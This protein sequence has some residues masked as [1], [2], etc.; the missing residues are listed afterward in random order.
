M[1]RDETIALF[2]ECEAKRAKAKAAAFAEG[3]SEDEAREIAHEAAKGHW[4]AWAEKLIAE[5]TGAWAAKKTPWG[6]LEPENAETRGGS[7]ISDSAVS[8]ISA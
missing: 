2:L 6:S 4:N 1:T 5:E 3:K 7:T 8:G